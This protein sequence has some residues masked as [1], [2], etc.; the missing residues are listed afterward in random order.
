M[1][2]ECASAAAVASSCDMATMGCWFCQTP[3]NKVQKPREWPW[4][5]ITQLACSQSGIQI[6]LSSKA[7]ALSCCVI[8]NS[9]A[10]SRLSALLVM[11]AAGTWGRMVRATDGVLTSLLP[12][13]GGGVPD[14][15]LGPLSDEALS[16]LLL[17]TFSLFHPPSSHERSPLL[18]GTQVPGGGD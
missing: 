18:R 11:S 15:S 13:S 12:P 5:K 2:V 8:G 17:A 9:G 6:Y 10:I 4:P 14:P 7:C 3:L 16:A 1:L